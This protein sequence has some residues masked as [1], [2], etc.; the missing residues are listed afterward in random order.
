[1][2]DNCYSTLGSAQLDESSRPQFLMR[3]SGSERVSERERRLA[4][5]VALYDHSSR[6]VRQKS[7]FD[8][9]SKGRP[10]RRRVQPARASRRCSGATSLR[11]D[12]ASSS[13]SLG[14]VDGNERAAAT[15]AIATFI[16]RGHQFGRRVFESA[17]LAARPLSPLVVARRR[18]AVVKLTVIAS[19]HDHDTSLCC[20]C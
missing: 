17:S 2:Y 8:R 20:C 4:D 10:R 16:A 6:S 7:V 18:R 3:A 12:R 13:S 9:H 5:R 15:T 1:M 14:A 11:V 19:D